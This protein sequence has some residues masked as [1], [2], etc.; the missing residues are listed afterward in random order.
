MPFIGLSI[1]VQILCAVHCVRNGRSPM[2]L[3]VI[4]FLSI[5]GCL[6]YAFFEILPQYQGRREVRAVKAAAAKKLDPERNI[7]AARE[8]L[9]LADTA[10]NRGALADALAESGRWSE[11]VEHYR[12]SQAKGPRGDRGAQLKLAR[13]QLESGNAAGAFRNLETLPP[14]GSAAENDRAALLLARAL[15]EC[16]E[17]DRALAA[18]LAV[19]GAHGVRTT[20]PRVL[21]DGS[22]GLI[23]RGFESQNEQGSLSGS[24][25]PAYCPS[26]LSA[27][28]T[29]LA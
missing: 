9:E 14:S 15:E 5:P 17:S 18:A 29:S 10:A 21:H 1:L 7:R 13:A 16:G 8:A 11:A 20:D 4:I 3:T 2:W 27:A 26:C 12:E 19:A 24:P 25:P 28:R 22:S 23:A 6:A